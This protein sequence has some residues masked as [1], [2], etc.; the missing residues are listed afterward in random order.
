[1]KLKKVSHEANTTEKYLFSSH[2]MITSAILEANPSL[3]KQKELFELALWVKRRNNKEATIAAI[4][5]LYN[6]SSLLSEK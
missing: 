4:Q 3:S 5:A 6:F 1:M 2:S